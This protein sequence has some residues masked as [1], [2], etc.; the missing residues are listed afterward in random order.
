MIYKIV[1]CVLTKKIKTTRVL[2][3]EPFRKYFKVSLGSILHFFYDQLLKSYKILMLRDSVVFKN[4][5]IFDGFT[6][7]IAYIKLKACIYT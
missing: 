7:E 2:V 1:N 3:S 5:S 4:N 6:R